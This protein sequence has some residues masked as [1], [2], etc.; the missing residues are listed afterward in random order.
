MKIV[1]PRNH[2]ATA[3]ILQSFVQR[4]SSKNGVKT[5]YIRPEFPPLLRHK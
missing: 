4:L 3:K 1:T 2:G 5:E